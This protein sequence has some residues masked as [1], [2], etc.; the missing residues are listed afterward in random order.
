MSRAALILGWRAA[1]LTLVVVVL[2]GSASASALERD[3]SYE[4]GPQT[5]FNA[6][7]G[8]EQD[9]ADVPGL[10]P[11]AATGGL[12]VIGDSISVPVPYVRRAADAGLRAHVRAWVGWTTRLHRMV[13]PWPSS[14][15]P[16]FRAALAGDAGAVFV[17][18]GTNDIGCLR[19]FLFCG[20]TP[21]PGASGFEQFGQDERAAINAEIDRSV[22]MLVDGGKCVL[23][24]GPRPWSNG[25]AP[26][27]DAAAFNDHL[28]ALQS[29]Y[30]GRFTYIDYATYSAENPALRADFADPDSD[31]M[32]P[33]TE[34]G[35]VAIADLAVSSALAHCPMTTEPRVAVSPPPPPPPPLTQP[36]PPPPP[37]VQPEPPPTPPLP[38]P[39]APVPEP[40]APE[41]P[42]E[43][44][45]P[46]APGCSAAPDA[47]ARRACFRARAVVGCHAPGVRGDCMRRVRRLYGAS[48]GERR[49]LQRCA[50]GPRAHRV[51]CRARAQQTY[52]FR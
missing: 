37:L 11:T 32:H 3:P 5:P 22:R 50:T 38:E 47:R 17:E 44:A 16:S 45:A 42:R 39:P 2:L 43:R 52:R 23:W 12:T 4:D 15:E 18:L 1:L 13:A 24:A 9:T 36:E 28:R 48:V 10:P 35:L 26:P 51:G 7:G 25:Y 41:L 19:A 14:G 8:I 31:G 21:K 30:P 20:G 49:A 34:A 6:F 40:P 33:R 29:I 46:R 27:E